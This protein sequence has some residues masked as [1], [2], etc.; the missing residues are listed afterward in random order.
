[1]DYILVHKAVKNKF[2]EH[3]KS[4][5]KAFYGEEIKSNPDFPRIINQ[6]HFERILS[7]IE[8][9]KIVC[10]GNTDSSTL[11]IEPTILDN[12]QWDDKI[13]QEEVFGPVLPIIEYNTRGEVI[14]KIKACPKP[15]AIYLF[16]NSRQVI[17]RIETET[18]SGAFVI[19]ETISHFINLRLPF[20]GVGHS[21]M[22]SYHGKMSFEAFTHK[23]PVLKK[24]TWLDLPIRYPAYE[25]KLNFVKKIMRILG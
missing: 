3:S 23:K 17:K 19:N 13:M 25:K 1:P 5:I 8:K 22:G 15:L 6:K 21:G 16:S 2:I 11:Y 14:E 12:V 18:S 9:D 4:F 7:L 24:S 10:G 20:G